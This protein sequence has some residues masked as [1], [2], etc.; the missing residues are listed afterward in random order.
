MEGALTTGQLLSFYTLVGFAMGPLARLASLSQDL[1]EARV[2]AERLREVL[3]EAPEQ[4]NERP[5]IGFTRLAR[6]IE[7][8]DVS[9]G[10]GSRSPVL[11]SLDLR[12]A[13]GSRVAIVGE[14]GCGKSTLLK[15]LLR[16]HEPVSGRF[17]VDGV[18]AS[19]LD[20]A[21]WRSRVAIVPQDPVILEGTLRENLCLGLEDAGLAEIAEATR[22]AGLDEFI[23]SL[24]ERYETAVGERGLDLSGGERQRIAIARAVLRR[25]EIVIFDEATSHLDAATERSVERNLREFLRGKTVLIVSHRLSAARDADI[26][27]VLEAGRIVESGH[28]DELRFRGGAYARLWES[29]SGAP[30]T[31]GG[32]PAPRWK[33]VSG[34]R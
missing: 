32:A 4:M 12:I 31:A 30:E 8:R 18:D 20:L 9:F 33:V 5:L 24:P 15:I 19:D 6:E 34:G 10:Y 11:D 27:H 7:L 14:S 1:E 13:A 29:Q 17:L 3:D 2:A 28:H 22:V 16:F 23:S 25:P 21:A 26:V